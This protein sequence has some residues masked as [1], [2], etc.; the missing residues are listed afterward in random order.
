MR[1]VPLVTKVHLEAVRFA[2]DGFSI[3]LVGP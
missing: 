1:P 3:V 2:R